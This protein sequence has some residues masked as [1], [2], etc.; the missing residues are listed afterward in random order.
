MTSIDPYAICPCG[1]GKKIKFCKCKDSVGLLDSI[2]QMIDGGQV[3][4]A[5]DKLS[6]VLS[7]NPD[8]A[9]AYAIRGRLLL[10]LREFD[11]LQE[12]AERF[13]R[14]QPSNPLALTQQAAALMFKGSLSEA[15]E[16]MLQALCESGKEVDSFVLDIASALAYS[17]ANEGLF[18]S[19]RVYATLA[20]MASGFDEKTM[21]TSVLS[22]LNHNAEIN[23]LIKAVPDLIE[24]PAD[25]SWGERYDEALTLLRS[26]QILLAQDKFESLQKTTAGEPAI[27][28]GL[29]TCAV[30]RGD[31][32][33]QTNLMKKISECQSLDME[34]RIRY[35]AM[36]AL[37][38]KDYSELSVPTYKLSGDLDNV[39]EAEM[40]MLAS[41]RF[42]SLPADIVSRARM[43]E[44]GVAPRSGFQFIAQD[45]PEDLE[46][47]PPME[48][49]IE[50][51]G[52]LFVFGKQT[53]REARIETEYVRAE[54][55]DEVSQQ[56]ES[57]VK[58][59]KLEKRESDSLPMIAT[60]TPLPAMVQYKVPIQEI[61]SHTKSWM[62]QGMPE[63]LA[64]LRLP[65]LGL[66]S[67]VETKDDSD[68]TLQRCATL[69][70]IEQ[71]DSLATE[72]GE[73]G[74]AEIYAAAGIQPPEPIKATDEEIE[75]IDNFKLSRIDVSA[76]SVTSLIYLIQRAGQVSSTGLAKRAALKL[77]ETETE[78][79]LEAARLLGYLT[80][81]RTGGDPR[82]A[83]GYIEK[84][85][86]FAEEHSFPTAE[87]LLSEV[88]LRLRLNDAVGFEAAVTELMSKYREQPE[89]MAQL[90]QMLTALGIIGPDGQPTRRPPGAPQGTAGAE[91]PGATAPAGAPGGL[92]TPEGASP[93][94]AQEGG[95]EAGKLW[96]PGMD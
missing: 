1:N 60:A 84:G 50:S 42:I 81:S 47:L 23:Q 56:I 26:N 72:L 40:A 88:P 89:V 92:W 52:I 82:E 18:L 93:S 74:L 51:H 37:V 29:L 10:S 35:L 21:S 33:D 65:I 20:A 38:A 53:D 83:L 77:I 36:S 19:A 32:E 34:Q 14:L 58:G 68:L 13:I 96:V 95:G 62:Q 67:L 30:W 48:E 11:S 43:E 66:K 46:K 63:T 5:L 80:L 6:S 86:A 69:L 54:R 27:L 73:K 44:D 76:L 9:W 71:Y 59:I 91:G 79:E 12:N 24:R 16:A 7:E 4:P 39:E 78:G 61:E 45:A 49:M 3:V 2:I 17:L 41:P 85:K 25:V 87:L 8:A 31:Q 90:Q 22:Q 70:V 28:S 64:S 55:V 94:P 15:T 57:T 75:K